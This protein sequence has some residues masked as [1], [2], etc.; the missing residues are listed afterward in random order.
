MNYSISH[1]EKYRMFSER[2]I[3]CGLAVFW[4]ILVHIGWSGHGGCGIYQPYNYVAWF[5]IS[6]SCMLFWLIRPIGKKISIGV[7]GQILFF[8]AMLMSLPLLWSPSSTAAS[9]ALPRIV[10]LWAGMAF[11]LTLRQ[12]H[13][14]ERNKF[15]LLY[16]LAGA[17]LI[18]GIIVIVELF[19][20]SSWLP[21]IW[22]K[23]LAERGRG[24]VGAFEQ[25]NVTA[26]FLGLSL[27]ACLFLFGLRRTTLT[28]RYVD[29]LRV[30]ILGAGCVLLP[31]V[32][33]LIY[34]RTGWLGGLAVVIGSY[35]MLTVSR[36]SGEGHRQKYLLLLPLAGVLIGLSAMHLSIAQA[37]AEHDGSNKQRLLTLYQT[38]IYASQHPLIGYGA[39]TYESHYQAWLAA[40]PGGNPGGEIMDHPHNEL[41]YQYSEGGI[42]ALSGALLWCGL[43][44]R[45]FLR[46][47][48]IVQAGALIGMLPIL[49]HTQLEYPL[50]YSAPHWLAL[51]ILLRIADKDM[52]VE[53]IRR[54]RPF[55]AY[56]GQIALFL[57]SVYGAVI[58]IQAY[59]TGR[60]LDLFENTE[61]DEPERIASLNVPW[62]QSSR[63][64]QD[65]AMLRLIRFR[66]TPNRASLYA[67]VQE[68]ERW[69]SVHVDETAYS[70]Q[71][72]VLK[73]LHEKQK[74]KAWETVAHKTL[75][76]VTDFKSNSE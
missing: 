66:T 43:Y 15:I 53:A 74:A 67:F 24:G 17:G 34:S 46:M 21:I 42:I 8:G 20:P 57:L 36:F 62:V 47:K 30:T 76:W 48:T 52:P 55:Y 70:N 10:G 18:E 51:L 6:V 37:L 29:R 38:F 59:S 33:T 31:A 16:C 68:N 45:L 9:N 35:I 60:I 73:Y 2:S 72:A 23:L 50:Y 7:T 14:S 41:L 75:P 65:M 26:S 1:E 63:Y 49:F 13:F 58:S 39:G 71:I 12:C 44:I 61:L 56:T 32:L 4:L 27:A 3:L 22:Q 28:S 69:L 19:G 40:L 25:V 11:W 64:Q 54:S 5:T